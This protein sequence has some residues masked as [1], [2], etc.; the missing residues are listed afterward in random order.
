MRDLGKALARVLVEG[1]GGA[2]DDA[3]RAHL[4][5]IGDQF[6]REGI[7]KVILGGIAGQVFKRQHGDRANWRSGVG[8][9]RQRWHAPQREHNGNSDKGKSRIW[10]QLP[11]T[12]AWRHS[13]GFIASCFDHLEPMY[14]F[15]RFDYRCN[16]TISFAR[17]RLDESWLFWVIIQSLTNL[18][19]GT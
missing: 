7:G 9:T 4:G 2:G 18:A 5:K 14:L 1:N 6:I 3:Q 8:V 16:E 17:Q 10:A 11:L 15:V 19:D 13:A 12:Y